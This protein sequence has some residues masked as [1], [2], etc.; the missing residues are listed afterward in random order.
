MN[1]GS[2]ELAGWIAVA[3]VLVS[4]AIPWFLWGVETT[5]AGLPVWLWWHV[6]WMLLAS[7]VF[8]L[9]A[10]RAWGIGIETGDGTDG[11]SDHTERGVESR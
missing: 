2:L 10:D 11:D 6:G 9:F 1:H 8:R 4:L 5:A 7:V 3:V